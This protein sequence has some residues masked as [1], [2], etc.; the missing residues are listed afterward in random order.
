V[1]VWDTRT[2]KELF[3]PHVPGIPATAAFSA[4]GRLF[5][6]GTQDGKLVFF[7]SR[8]GGQVGSPLQVSGSIVGQVSF[9]PD[10]GLFAVS[11]YDQTVSLWD[12]RT[13]KRLTNFPLVL[14]YVPW[15]LFTPK[16]DLLISYSGYGYLWP[17]SVSTWE[18]NACQVAG[19]DL[20]S[21]EWHDLLPT[22]PYLDVCPQ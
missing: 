14:G 4:D 7:D 2:G 13:R 6:V 21:A 17:T 15:P 20:T 10:G 1:T 22:R 5:S 9:S 11:A 3:A 18:R 19:R 16:G 12:L 8:S